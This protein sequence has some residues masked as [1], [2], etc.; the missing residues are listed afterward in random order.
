MKTLV[1]CTAGALNMYYV[2]HIHKEPCMVSYNTGMRWL[3]EVLRGHWQRCV[4][5]FRMDTSTLLSL[6]ND[7]EIKYGLKPSRRMSVIEKVAIFL[8]TIALGASNREVQVR[9]QLS[10][11][12]VSRCI[13]EVLVV[14]C[15]FAVDVIKLE[16]LNFTSTPQEIAMNPKYMPHFKVRKIFVLLLSVFNANIIL[17]MLVSNNIIISMFFFCQNCIGAIDGTHVRACIS[18]KNQIP[19]IGRK[20][21]PTQNI[22][23]TCNFNMRFTFV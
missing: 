8:Y 12:I 11:E 22:M 2:N 14:V 23:A 17:C 13:K 9:F 4:N 3:T 16:D 6:C 7:L 18:T 1:V 5:M 20:G 10:G 21:V 15:L 19:F